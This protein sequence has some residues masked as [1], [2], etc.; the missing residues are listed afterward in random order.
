MKKFLNYDLLRIILSII[1]LLLSFIIPNNYN[2]Y[3]L[4]TSYVI[5][6]YK[7][8]LKALKNILKKDFFDENFLMIIA[9]IGAFFIG[10]HL[11]AV[12][13]MLLF[14]IGEYL[15]D[16]AVSK[17]KDSISK[18]MDLKVE[19]VHLLDKDINIEKVKE[20]DIFIVKVGERI[21]LDGI[22][23]EGTSLIDTS[24]IT[25]ESLPKKVKKDDSVISGCI[26]QKSTL[27]IKATSN[28]KTTTTKRI[29]DLVEKSEKKK[30]N[31]ENFIH[32]FAKIYTPVIC[33]IALL[34]VLIPLLFGIDY[35]PWLYRALIFLVTSCPCA[36]VISPPLG[37]FCGIGK[38]AKEGILVKGA[39]ELESLEKV[40]Y[41]FLDKTGTITEGV[42]TITE[43]NTTL[44]EDE[45]LKIIASAE[46]NSIHPISQAIL[47][48]Y[49]KELEKVT[50]YQEITG[51]GIKCIINNNTVLVG[52]SKLMED[53]NIS[54][55]NN[56][57]I[58]TTIYLAVNN[59]YKG[60][61]VISDKIKESS[62]NIKDLNRVIT[63]DII[64]L[65]GDNELITKKVAEKT[66]IKKYYGNLLPTSKVEIVEQYKKK[67]ITAFIGDGI[68]DAPVITTADIG[69]SMGN[70]G[71][72]AAI[73]ASD[74][75]LM[76][77]NLERVK[78]MIEISRLTKRKVTQSI[79]FA[80]TIKLLVLFLSIF[81]LSTILLAVFADVGVTIISIIYV[82]SIF[83]HKYNKKT[84][85]LILI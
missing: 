24:S 72:D 82:L 70:L 32:K 22:I 59:E 12:L 46:I 57:S 8:Y 34:L 41:L 68:N 29:I 65:S 25:G 42:F 5:I 62:K 13:V 69:I 85:I 47:N 53:N 66:G 39:K 73:E 48:V 18:L 3:L 33:I 35:K 27:T 80:L 64:I 78:D 56:N 2:L 76:T 50:N 55:K 49:S 38:A 63:K 43:I 26:N 16:L 84:L 67:G 19:K 21:P 14:E 81:G 36:L 40:D 79:I 75:V 51:K 11:E 71:S 44:K 4:I 10:S 60:N 15:S 30:S 37:Y 74:V 1:I 54:Y 6:S 23:I 52:N 45:F 17:S 28:Y 31:T 7:I 83:Y 61:I 20:K 58:G 9:T 77:D